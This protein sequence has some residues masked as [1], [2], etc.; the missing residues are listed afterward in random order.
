MLEL[1]KMQP[2]NGA[3]VLVK[4]ESENPTGS[5]K[6]G[7]ALAMI[8]AAESDGRLSPGGL[9]VEY[10]GGS[11]GVSL[12]M[13]CAVKRH[14]LH[15]V[16]SDA[17]AQEKLDQMRIFGARLQI[18]KSESGGMTGKLT[19]DMVAAAREVMQRTG[20]LWTDQL[21]NTDQ[22]SAYH[23]MAEEIW[24]Q[25]SG[26]IDG[27]VQSVGRRRR[28]A[29][30]QSDCAHTRARSRLLPLSHRNRLCCQVACRV[31]TKL[32]ELALGLSCRCG[33]RESQIRS[34][35]SRRKMPL[36]WRS[37][38]RVK[39]VSLR[40]LRQERTSLPRCGWRRS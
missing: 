35:R 36:R 22:L 3:R 27:F 40:E 9:V 15:I 7:M 6:D 5:M 18:V 32:M 28:C 12:A 20:A 19:R 16:S 30:L 21:H 24:R 29:E 34:N 8:E 17:F 11:T 14:P 23:S 10:T 31:P 37:G 2:A 25:T 13:V 38:W 26:A 4:L 33:T 1:G 39:K